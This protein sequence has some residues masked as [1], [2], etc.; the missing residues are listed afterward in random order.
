[1]LHQ[2]GKLGL[3]ILKRTWLRT[4]SQTTNERKQ[5]D[6][7]SPIVVVPK[8]EGKIRICVDMR[9]AS[10]AVKRIRHP[11]PTVKDM[12]L[13]LNGA[14]Y[15]SKLDL[16][17]AYHQLELAPESRP[18]TTFTTPFGFYRSKSLNYGTNS[19]AEILQHALQQSLQGIEG[20]RN[21]ADDIIVFGKTYEAHNKSLKAC[22]Q[23]L[24][25]HNLTLNINKCKFLKP[26]LEFFGFLFTAEGTQLDP[27][28][29]SAFVKSKPPKSVSEVRS[30]A[31]PTTVHNS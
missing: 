27:K 30:L 28:K 31:W 3:Q 14:K 19:S 21:L 20:V 29:V 12:A 1:M 11:I 5:T 6:W 13:E 2:D 10:T 15:L 16:A 22:L 7:V 18:I 9:A 17:Q 26:N 8:K 23:R 4:P 24:Q 25:E